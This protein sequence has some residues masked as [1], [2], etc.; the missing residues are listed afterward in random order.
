AR[1][2]L[3]T[4]GIN[5]VVCVVGG[6]SK[7]GLESALGAYDPRTNTWTTKSSMPTPRYGL[8]VVAVNG[9]LYAMG[10]ENSNGPLSIVEA[11]DPATDTWSTRAPIPQA[12]SFPVGDVSKGV[13][14]LA[15]CYDESLEP[16]VVLC[17]YDHGRDSWN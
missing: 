4:A 5:G 10:G 3:G 1:S 6:I 15:G 13:V 16:K 14:Y 2:A 8:A 11:Y 9:I 7:S 12:R 17:A